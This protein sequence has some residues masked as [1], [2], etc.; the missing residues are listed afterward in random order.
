MIAMPW[1]SWEDTITIPLDMVITV[2]VTMQVEAMVALPRTMVD[3]VATNIKVDPTTVPTTPRTT[4]AIR[5][6]E[7]QR[8]LVLH[9][10][11]LVCLIMKAIEMILSRGHTLPRFQRGV[12]V[13]AMHHLM[14]R[15]ILV[16]VGI[17]SLVGVEGLP[18]RLVMELGV[19]EPTLADMALV[20]VEALM[21]L[22]VE[23]LPVEEDLAIHPIPCH[24]P[25]TKVA[26]AT[27]LTR[28]LDISLVAIKE[29]EVETLVGGSATFP[30]L[31]P[32]PLLNHTLVDAA[33]LEVLVPAFFLVHTLLAFSPAIVQ[34]MILELPV[35]LSRAFSKLPT[36]HT[37]L[38][39]RSIH[40]F[41]EAHLTRL[42]V[43]W[44]WTR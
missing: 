36:I 41:L 19:E 27:M 2:A 38:H 11:N 6:E 43:L 30:A 9:P 3:I 17:S 40:P 25:S 26:V 22:E 15:T 37:R 33:S 34:T 1:D 18:D 13:G 7:W 4:M 14:Q 12:Q 24:L 44:V 31:C 21:A 23:G 16:Q 28:V 10:S 5:E 29:V 32:L 42:L 20:W 35:E 8:F 39:S